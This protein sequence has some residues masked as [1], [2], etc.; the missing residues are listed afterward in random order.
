MERPHEEEPIGYV[1]K[2]AVRIRP[3]MARP[4]AGPTWWLDIV[5]CE[6]SR[7]GPDIPPGSLQPESEVGR[8]AHYERLVKSAELLESHPPNN[9]GVG[10]RIRRQKASLQVRN[11]GLIAS[12]QRMPPAPRVERGRVDPHDLGLRLVEDGGH[13]RPQGW[14][15]REKLKRL[16]QG[17]VKDDIVVINE[18]N[19]LAGALF[20]PHVSSPRLEHALWQ[21]NVSQAQIGEFRSE[22]FDVPRIIYDHN[23]VQPGSAMGSNTFQKGFEFRGTI[24]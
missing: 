3:T 12:D 17:S 1:V 14:T 4:I 7:V 24:M 21:S 2:H 11:A 13:D 16:P 23:R 5:E 15:V 8:P 22:I 18:V 19:E 20:P 10:Q 9:E 6:G